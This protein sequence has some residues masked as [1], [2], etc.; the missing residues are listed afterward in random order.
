MSVASP[1]V[2]PTSMTSEPE[3]GAEIGRARR[4]R[5]PSS[6][7]MRPPL[8]PAAMAARDARAHRGAARRAS[9]RPPTDV[10]TK[11]EPSLE[12]APRVAPP[13]PP[14]GE[15][16]LVYFDPRSLE[17]RTL[18]LPATGARVVAAACAAL[19]LVS[20]ALGFG[21]SA[22]LAALAPGRVM[23][24]ASLG[25]PALT[26]IFASMPGMDASAAL[27]APAAEREP[28]AAARARAERLGLGTV[29]AASSLIGG[30]AKPEWVSAARELAEPPETLAWPVDGGWFVRGYGS[31]TGAYH[32]A[33][34]VAAPVGRRVRAAA[35]G[36]VAYADDEIRGFGNLLLLVHA[37]GW[38]TLYAHNSKHHVVA[39][40]RVVAGQ[41]IAEVGSTGISRGP[42]VHFELMH[43]GKNC[44]PAPLFRP[45]ILHRDGDLSE[46]T[47]ADWNVGE[48]RPAQ[49]RCDRRRIHPN[50]ARLRGHEGELDG[51]E[52]VDADVVEAGDA[53][54]SA[55]VSERGAA[56]V[57]G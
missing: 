25:V 6:P 37:N 28:A 47:Q 8:R 44:D 41:L 24:Q 43:A 36:I 11:V 39:G 56:V 17:S 57:E 12:A 13:P 10:T 7:S 54:E 35:D 52:H 23:T 38:I 51:H 26:A 21:A 32:L 33:V 34:D 4:S 42:H 45:G 15:I 16:T 31:G 2:P 3:R 18:A 48:G 27:R 50:S 55:A 19:F 40:E 30:F 5:R 49:V 22:G 29:A 9:V 1:S 46:I 53:A 14:S 20:S